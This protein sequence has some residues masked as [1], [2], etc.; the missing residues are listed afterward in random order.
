MTMRVLVLGATGMLGNAMVRLLGRT[1]RLRVTAAARSADVA[2]WFPADLEV[3]YIGEV[4][5]QSPDSLTDLFARAR[6][7]VVI[8]CVG[9]VKQA[10]DSKHVMASV[11]LNTLL[12]HRLARLAQIGDA[13]LIHISTDCVFSGKTGN[14]AE[15]DPPDAADV[16]GPSKYLGEPHDDHAITLRTSIIGH[17]LRGRQGLLEWFLAQPGPVKGFTRAVFSGMPTVELAKIVRDHVLPRPQLS[18]LYHVS[19]EP[20]AKYDL[21]KLVAKEYGKSITIV[22][23]DALVLDRSLNSDRFRAVAGYQP[24][25]WRELVA[26]MHSFG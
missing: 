7:E 15:A 2:K 26:A 19:A 24:P 10:K 6:P 23:D 20:I 22:P 17:E 14:Y 12:P 18:G 21:L 13:R 1:S 4:E 3:E 5:A 11:P 25:S 8:N 16:Y 9:L